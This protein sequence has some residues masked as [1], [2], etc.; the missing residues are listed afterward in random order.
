MH[1]HIVEGII[2]EVRSSQNA[3][4]LRLNLLPVVGEPFT[5]NQMVELDCHGKHARYRHQSIHRLHRLDGEALMLLIRGP[6]ILS[7]VFVE[8]ISLVAAVSAQYYF[9]CHSKNA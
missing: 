9:A 6:V 7:Y 5:D 8:N 4:N 3:E 2:I 1:D